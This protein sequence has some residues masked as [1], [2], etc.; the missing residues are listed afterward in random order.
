MFGEQF[1]LETHAIMPAT[2]GGGKSMKIVYDCKEH[3]L[4][5]DPIILVDAK[6]SAYWHMLTYYAR[7]PP[8]RP[9]IP[10]NPSSGT[11]SV[12]I[13]FFHPKKGANVSAH[14]SRVAEVIL[15]ALGMD[16]IANV[17]LY[18]K[19]VN[20][21]M[22]YVAASGKPIGQAME[23]LYFQN[24]HLAKEAAE[25]MPNQKRRLDWLE[26]YRKK[27]ETQ[28]NDA[29]ASTRLRL[30]PFLTIDGL[31][32]TFGLSDGLSIQDAMEDGANILVNLT[33]SDDFPQEACRIFGAVLTSELLSFSFKHARDP[34]PY[35]IYLDE[36]EMYAS[37]DLARALQVGRG[38][39]LRFTLS[40][41]E[42]GE[43]DPRLVSTIKK[44][45]RI[46]F[47]GAGVTPEEAQAHVLQ[48][49]HFEVNLRKKKDDRFGIANKQY[50]WMND[51]VTTYPDGTQSETWSSTFMSEPELMVTGQEDY[52]LQ[53]KLSM[54]S[55]G[56]YLDLQHRQFRVEEPGRSYLFEVPIVENY[57][58]DPEK[59]LEF[60]HTRQTPNP[61]IDA[62]LNQ[63]E[64]HARPRI[65]TPP[66]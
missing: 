52:T 51:S 27:S 45:C 64:S 48:H 4:D 11:H 32:R 44:N 25:M 40:F 62:E 61:I 12:P 19:T 47:I 26:L 59:V 41:H 58:H 33:P 38:A 36:V 16:G 60:E 50:P 15:N 28:Y 31:H 10:I 21:L 9:V 42:D 23:A 37:P 29:T 5:D 46:K 13:R 6:E 22:C 53:E 66:R 14:A 17:P 1:D 57:L 30:D 8:N 7:L 2:T 65:K 24:R 20:M 63:Q 39:G 35:F 3:N 34:I 43:L 49:H 55:S 54:L 18:R 56:L